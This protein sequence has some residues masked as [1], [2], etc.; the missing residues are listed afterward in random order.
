MDFDDPQLNVDWLNLSFY[1][2][3]EFETII[4]EDQ[5]PAFVGQENQQSSVSPS[6]ADYGARCLVKSGSKHRYVRGTVLDYSA[7]KGKFLFRFED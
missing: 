4:H 5:L 7:E 3:R 2:D 6:L 1:D